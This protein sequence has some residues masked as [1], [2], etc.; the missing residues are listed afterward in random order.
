MK[1]YKEKMINLEKAQKEFKNYIEQFEK[2]DS[3][4]QLKIDH[5]FRVVETSKTIAE[6]L[7]LSDEEVKLAQLIALLHD[8]GRFKQISEF[9]TCI[10]EKSMD[11]AE[12]GANILVGEEKKIRLFISSNEY[13][14]IIEKAV[15][16]HS[17]YSLPKG[18]NKQEELQAKIVRDA[19]K[20][21][22][23][24]L[25]Q[26]QNIHDIFKGAGQDRLDTSTITPKVYQDFC[27]EKCIKVTDRKTPAD[28]WICIIAFI[29][30]LNFAVS[31]QMVKEN[32]YIDHIIDRLS[33]KNEQTAK[34]IEEIRK[35][36]NQYIERKV[37]EVTK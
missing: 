21:D 10:D 28:F 25:K 13:D 7:G 12:Y 22:N 19:D 24:Y 33:F 35:R 6:K 1:S 30:D 14:A 5:T 31:Y 18:L 3:H 4:I 9:Q 17:K 15:R 34:Q 16:N 20:L 26:F 2:T 37:N 23:L 29:F 36:T 8:I 11:H 27:Q 32:N